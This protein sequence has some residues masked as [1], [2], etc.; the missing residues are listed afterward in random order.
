MNLRKRRHKYEGGFG[1]RKSNYIIISKFEKLIKDNK[2]EMK[3]FHIF[4]II[5]NNRAQTS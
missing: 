1:R 5:K 2:I 4:H 3:F